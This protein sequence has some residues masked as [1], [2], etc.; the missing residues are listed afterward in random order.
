M[1]DEGEEE[2][3][4]L[5]HPIPSFAEEG[6]LTQEREVAL[7]RPQGES[8]W[9]NEES[10]CSQRSIMSCRNRT[11]NTIL[12]LSDPGAPTKQRCEKR[13]IYND[14]DETPI[15]NSRP[16]L[17]HNLDFLHD[18]SSV[19]FPCESS[20]PSHITPLEEAGDSVDLVNHLSH[21]VVAVSPIQKRLLFTGALD[22]TADAP[23]GRENLKGVGSGMQL[24]RGKRFLR[25]LDANRD[26]VNSNSTS[27]TMPRE[28]HRKFRR[29][30]VGGGDSASCGNRFPSR[31]QH[32]R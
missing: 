3:E 20:A 21:L 17:Y 13:Y 30:D 18:S 4:L 32:E 11:T 9:L 15:N 5:I 8:Q 24:F 16:A 7:W 31:C 10:D 22:D 29:V 27:L 26:A 19:S 2:E 12:Q 1:T 28:A 25:E 23:S 14:A 6:R